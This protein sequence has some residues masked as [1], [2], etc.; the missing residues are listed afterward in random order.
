[1]NLRR[2]LGRS[3][4]RAEVLVDRHR[5]F[6]GRCWFCDK[7]L[8][9]VFTSVRRG[10]NSYRVHGECRAPAERMILNLNGNRAFQDADRSEGP[11]LSELHSNG[12][13]HH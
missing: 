7:Q 10:D 8:T 5:T 3:S 1:M 13:R 4:V 9:P 6:Y 2:L 12:S 11:K